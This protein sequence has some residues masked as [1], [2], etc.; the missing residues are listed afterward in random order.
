MRVGRVDERRLRASWVHQGLGGPFSEASALSVAKRLAET[1]AVVELM[2]TMFRHSLLG[3][4]RVEAVLRSFKAQVMLYNCCV[5][6][7]VEVR[8]NGR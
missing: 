6:F 8:R 1:E 2:N 4:M 7:Y 3:P 5:F